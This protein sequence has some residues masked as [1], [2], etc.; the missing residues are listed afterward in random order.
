MKVF[1]GQ[2]AA[3]A[4]A[5]TAGGKRSIAALTRRAG[6]DSSIVYAVTRTDDVFFWGANPKKTLNLSSDIVGK[7]PVFVRE[8]V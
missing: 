6:Y 7:A 1:A 4:A 8:R 5:A 3:A 2:T